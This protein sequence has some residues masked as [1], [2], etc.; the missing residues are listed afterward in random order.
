MRSRGSYSYMR[1]SEWTRATKK[2]TGLCRV[3]QQSAL[4][5]S[6]LLGE[7]PGGPGNSSDSRL[8]DSGSGGPLGFERAAVSLRRAGRA[9][10]RP[11]LG[12]AALARLDGVDAYDAQGR[13]RHSGSASAIL[14]F[15]AIRRKGV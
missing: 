12:A 3:R 4:A 5:A 1:A 9:S 8:A 10:V 14:V 6:G 2:G 15:A 11:L 7:V 13:I